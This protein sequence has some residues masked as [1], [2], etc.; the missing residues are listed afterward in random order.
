LCKRTSIINEFTS[1]GEVNRCAWLTRGLVVG[2]ELC[3]IETEETATP[4]LRERQS[5]SSMQSYV[6]HMIRYLPDNRHPAD[7]GVPPMTSP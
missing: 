1:F 4:I 2:G 5:Y 7:L 3:A 6:G